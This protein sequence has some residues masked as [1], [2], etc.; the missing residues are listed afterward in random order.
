MNY[1][2]KLKNE[3]EQ[4]KKGIEE[5][6]TELIDYQRYYTLPKFE[7]TENDFAHVKTDVY[8]KITTIKMYL[9]HT[10]NAL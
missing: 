2:T 3:N 10:L 1:I 4:L 5:A 7:G 9:Q 6:I 8:V